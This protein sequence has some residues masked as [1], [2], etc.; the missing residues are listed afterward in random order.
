MVFIGC[1]LFIQQLRRHGIEVLFI[2]CCG[3]LITG[4]LQHTLQQYGR[5]ARILF[6]PSSL[7]SGH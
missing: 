6:I 5:D 4:L 1:L 3:Y 2:L 7:S